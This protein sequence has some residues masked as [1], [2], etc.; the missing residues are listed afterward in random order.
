MT[1]LSRLGLAI[2]RPRAAFAVA[3][4]R[5]H[6]GRSGSDLL[7]LILIV[8]LATQLRGI[9]GAIWLGS[10]VA[11]GLGVQALVRVLTDALVV[12]LGF[13]VIGAL[14]IWA[15]SGTRRDLGRA[16]DVAC[17]AVLPLV[18]LDL[19]ATV[20]VTALGVHVPHAAM[21]ALSIVAY[22][23]TLAWILL[24]VLEM[25]GSAQTVEPSA[26][27]TRAGWG[28][29]TVALAGL[30]V[31]GIW[32]VNHLDAVR[33]MTT[34]EPAPTFTL[35][36]IGQN[37][38]FAL[39]PG[40]VTVI[41]FWATWCQPCLRSLP[42]LEALHKAHPE[43]DVVAINIDDPKDAADL[44]KEEGY[45]MTLVE[46]DRQTQAQYGVDAIPHTVIIDKAGRVQRVLR[47]GHSDY[48]SMI[49]PLLR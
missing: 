47:G 42:K 38:S 29:A 44:F 23:W 18:L 7:A 4:D 22:A 5:E 14:I 24:A 25:R 40:K 12:D 46:G 9:V 27:A 36:V 15:F 20:V 17:V 37:T 6:A 31:Q 16:F 3:A 35:P 33:P 2:V 39:R 28:I 21:I 10:A 49:Q 45:T 13:L 8:L 41:D 43:I 26:A 34:G 48:E 11:G 19:V 32:L 30:A 1:F